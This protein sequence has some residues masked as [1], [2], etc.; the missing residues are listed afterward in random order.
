M[1]WMV[2]TQRL[3]S[4]KPRNLLLAQSTTQKETTRAITAV[5]YGLD[6]AEITRLQDT[7]NP[8]SD[9]AVAVKIQKARLL[10]AAGGFPEPAVHGES[11][12]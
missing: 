2:D 5:L 1:V 8:D 7:G 9:P 6:S 10:L 4:P 12:R 11:R 3:L